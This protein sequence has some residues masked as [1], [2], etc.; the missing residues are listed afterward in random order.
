MCWGNRK[1]TSKTFINF[2]IFNFTMHACPPSHRVAQ[3][4]YEEIVMHDGVQVR[5]G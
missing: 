2:E 5:F 3:G 1:P 4:G